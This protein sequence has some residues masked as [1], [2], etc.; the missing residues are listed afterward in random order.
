MQSFPQPKPDGGGGPNLLDWSAYQTVYDFTGT[1]Q[2][3]PATTWKTFVDITGKGFLKWCRVSASSNTGVNPDIRLTIDGQEYMFERSSAGAQLQGNEINFEIPFKNS[4]KIEAFNFDGSSAATLICDY[5]YL[6]Q[7]STP[8]ERKNTLLLQSSRKMAYASGTATALTDVLNI[9]GSGYLLGIS[10]QGYY[11]TAQASIFGD[12]AIDGL[13]KI[14][15]RMV[16]LPSTS[17][18][19]KQSDFVGPIRF[20]TSL[21]I[22]SRIEAAGS[23]YVVFAWYCLD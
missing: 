10:F 20:N 3:V 12:L 13:Q 5:L 11:N 7:V 19:R 4:L 22:R 16:F 8:S 23:T 9:T 17:A 15:D 1:A 2:S 6:V 14:T 18:Q 21:R